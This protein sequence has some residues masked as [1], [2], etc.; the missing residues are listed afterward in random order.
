MTATATSTVKD[1]DLVS[2]GLVESASVNSFADFTPSKFNQ[3]AL[4]NKAIEDDF[5]NT[6]ICHLVFY[7]FLC[8]SIVLHV[9]IDLGF[10]SFVKNIFFRLI[11]FGKKSF[12]DKRPA[13]A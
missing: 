4:I 13:F 2:L 3:T 10:G 8:V 9:I 11:Q 1:L 12:F 7:A 6:F 5:I